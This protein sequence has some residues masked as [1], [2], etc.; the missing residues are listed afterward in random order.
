MYRNDRAAST[1]IVDAGKYPIDL[2]PQCWANPV[3][4]HDFL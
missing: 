2:K 4:I 1:D 3:E